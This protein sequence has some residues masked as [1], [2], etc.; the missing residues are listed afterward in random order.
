MDQKTICAKRGRFLCTLD[1]GHSGPH[2]RQYRRDIKAEKS[3]IQ[4]PDCFCTTSPA[5]NCPTHG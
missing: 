1:K 3:A 2:G 5:V 4:K